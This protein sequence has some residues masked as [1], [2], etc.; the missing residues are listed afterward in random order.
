MGFLSQMV[1]TVLGD[2]DGELARLRAE[3]QRSVK[4]RKA[5]Q[6]RHLES[7]GQFMLCV[8]DLVDD[9]AAAREVNAAFESLERKKRNEE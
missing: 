9:E 5:A 4:E 2:V 8:K 1:N 3:K 6:E 7:S